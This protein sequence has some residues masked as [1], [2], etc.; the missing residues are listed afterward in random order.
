MD[1]SRKEMVLGRINKR[2]S[3]LQD[4]IEEDEPIY[5]YSQHLGELWGEFKGLK[6]AERLIRGYE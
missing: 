2:I 1:D 6:K 4:Q 3:D 5:G